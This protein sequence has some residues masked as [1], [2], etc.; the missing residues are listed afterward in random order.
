[1]RGHSRPELMWGLGLTEKQQRAIA[2]A[3]GQGFELRN[4]AAAN[5][6][7]KRELEQADQPSILWIP[8]RIWTDMPEFRRQAYRDMEDTQRVLILEEDTPAPEY[9]QVLEQ[10]FLTS[11]A[12]PMDKAKV[13]DALFRAKE[14]TSLYSDLYSMTEEIMLERELLKRKTDQLLFLNKLLAQAT[15]TLDAAEILCRAGELLGLL[16]P[17]KATQ[18]VFWQHDEASGECELDIFLPYPLENKAAS[19]WTEFLIDAASRHCG[20]PVSTFQ[21]IHLER[22]AKIQGPLPEHGRVL[23]LPL[24]AGG[25]PFGVLV[26]LAEHDVRLAKDQV[27]TLRAAAF[28]LGLALKNALL[29]REVKGQADRDG[30]TRV[31]NRR[32]FDEA[33]VGEMRRSQRYDTDLALLMLDLDH[34]KD[35]N[36][37]YGHQAGDEVL[38]RIGEIL[39]DTVRTT[40]MPARYGGEEFA[41]LLPHTCQRDAWKLAERIREIIAE[42]RFDSGKGTFSVTASIG[43][44]SL[45]SGPLDHED[46]L[47]QGADQAL[48]TAKANGRNMVVANPAAP[49][50]AMPN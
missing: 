6:P 24:K 41:V 33:L 18:A 40:D 29:Y 45:K 35:I 11:I 21:L 39:K 4:Y 36:D 48:Y 14:V 8:W 22:H 12:A 27:Q 43:V 49:A 5:Q 26:L 50:Q 37:Q 25:E 42:Q 1:M 46:E 38:R 32:T 30:L 7:W 23:S 16:V 31:F 20:S 47:L 17:V 3:A 9:E 34:F 28:H 44:S 13:Q 2:G 15:E 19:R 10:G